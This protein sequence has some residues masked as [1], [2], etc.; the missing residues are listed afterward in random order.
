MFREILFHLLWASL[1]LGYNHMLNKS[2][3]YRRYTYAIKNNILSFTHSV[4]SFILARLYL[5]EVHYTAE[6]FL[7]DNSLS[8]TSLFDT[9]PLNNSLVNTTSYIGT[10]NNLLYIYNY[11]ENTWSLTLLSLHAMSI[12][13]FIADILYLINANLIL[14]K[15]AYIFHHVLMLLLHYYAYTSNNTYQ[16][17][18]L[19]YYGELS[20]FFTYITYHF[21]KTHQHNAAYISTIFQCIWFGFYRIMVYSSFLIPFFITVNSVLLRLLLPCIYVMGILWWM[22]L[23]NKTYK[24][25]VL[26]GHLELIQQYISQLNTYTYAVYTKWKQKINTKLSGSGQTEHHNELQSQTDIKPHVDIPNTIMRRQPTRTYV[27]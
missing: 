6:Q 14:E 24:N 25:V 1:W 21:I 17:I 27:D 15:G 26:R 16:Y 2:N 20:N 23:W 18:W 12:W 7:Y 19:F 11:V 10:Y 22:N 5:S 9:Y 3:T 4:L 8:N 13:Y